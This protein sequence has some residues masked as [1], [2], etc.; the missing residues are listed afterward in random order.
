MNNKKCL[1]TSSVLM[2]ITFNHDYLR[3]KLL[4][5]NEIQRLNKNYLL[6]QL[7]QTYI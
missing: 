6:F 4:V 5:I 7:L 3:R 1:L 2:F